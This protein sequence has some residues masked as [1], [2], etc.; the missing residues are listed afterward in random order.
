MSFC[1]FGI[2]PGEVRIGATI[3]WSAQ[4]QAVFFINTGITWS[5]NYFLSLSLPTK[6]NF[7]H[8]LHILYICFGLIPAI[9]RDLSQLSVFEEGGSS[10]CSIQGT[11]CCWKLNSVY[12]Q[13]EHVLQFVKLFTGPHNLFEVSRAIL[14]CKL[15][16]SVDFLENVFFAYKYLLT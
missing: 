16:F 11:V 15:V 4:T 12:L 1:G 5:G 14:F 10:L 13:S 2:F 8:L 3:Y 9:L 7:H 6:Q